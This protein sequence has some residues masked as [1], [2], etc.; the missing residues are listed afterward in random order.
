MYFMYKSK[1]NLNPPVFR[2]LFPPRTNIK[3]VLRNENSI[4]DPPGMRHRSD[5]QLGLI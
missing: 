5:V 2:N 1:Q 4:E 3:Y